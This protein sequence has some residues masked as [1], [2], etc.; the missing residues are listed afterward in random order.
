MHTTYLSIRM[1]TKPTVQRGFTLVE[2]LVVI[3]I[4]GI[5]V[6]LLL[7]AVNAAREA[8]RKT[9][10]KN[11]M[12]QIGVAINTY[13]EANKVFPPGRFGCSA[14]AQTECGCSSTSPVIERNGASG[15]VALL[16]YMEEKSLYSKMRPDLG[17]V[18]NWTYAPVWSTDE[19]NTLTTARPRVFICPSSSS[20]ATCEKC[21]VSPY[22]FGNPSETTAGTGNYALCGGSQGP[23]WGFSSNA[24]VCTND[25]LFSY[26]IR[27]KIKS[28][29]DGIS[30]TFAAG[31]V[32]FVDDPNAN[33]FWAYGS[34]NENTLRSTASELNSPLCDPSNPRPCGAE[35]QTFGWGSQLNGSFGSEHPGGG[36]FV[37]AD[38]HVSFIQ[39]EINLQTYRALSTRAGRKPPIVEGTVNA[40]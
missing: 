16:P 24:A 14:N 19:R 15:F 35:T 32:R 12:K 1:R 4:I 27:R 13:V 29:T 20:Q 3:A 2:L 23:T 21:K 26:R 34:M 36:H 10:C 37:Y 25:G 22:N 7:P 40:E 11:N 18:F 28:V 31:E 30:K 6:A 8:A 33:N 9:Q 5:L 17:G 39:D 38:G